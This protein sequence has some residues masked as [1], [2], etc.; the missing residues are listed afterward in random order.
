MSQ[1]I[2]RRPFG[3]LDLGDELRYTARSLSALG[4]YS[5]CFLQ[6]NEVAFQCGGFEGRKGFYDGHGSPAITERVERNGSRFP[7][8]SLYIN[9]RNA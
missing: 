3:E 9:S 2:I 1:V 7:S 8:I 6:F 5:D 4:V